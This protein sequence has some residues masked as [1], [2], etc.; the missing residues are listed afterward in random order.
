MAQLPYLLMTKLQA[1][2]FR[3][4]TAGDEHRLDPREVT[5][6]PHAGKSALP[7]GVLYEPAYADRHDAFLMLGNA[8]VLEASTAF[9]V[10]EDEGRA[11]PE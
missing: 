8:V 11:A 6:G 10:A 5:N 1:A 3:E 2:R 7:E 9:Y 4:E